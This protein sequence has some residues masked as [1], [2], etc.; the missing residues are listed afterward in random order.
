VSQSD[1][2]TTDVDLFPGQ[3]E[4]LLRRAGDDRE[5]LVELPQGDVVLAHAR[6]LEREGHGEGRGGGE[7]DGRAGGVGVAWQGS[8]RRPYQRVVTTS[9]SSLHIE[10]T[11]RGGGTRRDSA[12]FM[13]RL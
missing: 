13:G 3:V 7:V 1:G 8:A 9:A 12:R 5:R 2:T 11:A 6:G 10:A 4:H